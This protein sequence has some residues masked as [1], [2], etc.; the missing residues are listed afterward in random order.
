ME[1]PEHQQPTTQ[2]SLTEAVNTVRGDVNVLL[3]DKS[4][5]L[6]KEKNSENIG[7]T[8]PSEQ[9]LLLAEVPKKTPILADLAA[10]MNA[11]EEE[12]HPKISK[13]LTI[14]KN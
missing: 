9:E 13:I 8:V 3:E 1:A 6:P 12:S 2:D 4:T 11:Q 7:H 5:L 14:S 10:L